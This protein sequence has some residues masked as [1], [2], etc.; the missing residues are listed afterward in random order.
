[1]DR[2]IIIGCVIVA[3]AVL[4]MFAL[5]I[6]N[7]SIIKRIAKKGYRTAREAIKEINGV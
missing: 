1:M 4:C 5:A 7:Y 6:W 2:D 3:T